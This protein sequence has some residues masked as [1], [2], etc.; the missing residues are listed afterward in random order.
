MPSVIPACHLA[1]SMAPNI[2]Q[3]QA[4][5]HCNCGRRRSQRLP[6]R[7]RNN[8]VIRQVRRLQAPTT[9]RCL[10]KLQSGP[11]PV[12]LTSLC[13]TLL[14]TPKETALA[15]TLC[16]TTG[17]ARFKATKAT[18]MYEQH[19]LANLVLR[20]LRCLRQKHEGPGPTVG[21]RFLDEKKFGVRIARLRCR[22]CGC[23]WMPTF[24]SR[25]L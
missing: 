17:T 19:L 11:V 8:N 1:R 21:R 24:F 12:G 3:A 20:P 13:A 7:P 15:I 6:L 14:S 4:P 16:K 5:S 18:G 9:V 25:P 2:R 22:S 10:G 23:F